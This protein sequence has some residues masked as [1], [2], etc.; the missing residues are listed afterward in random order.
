MRARRRRNSSVPDALARARHRRVARLELLDVQ[1]AVACWVDTHAPRLGQQR[2]CVCGPAVH[3]VA[4]L[5]P[6]CGARCQQH[7]PVDARRA[8][9]L[10]DVVQHGVA[11]ARA[12][13]V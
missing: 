8:R 9:V 1:L 6:V 12:P 5:K 2:A 7:Q 13:E 3:E 11:A 4:L 10:L